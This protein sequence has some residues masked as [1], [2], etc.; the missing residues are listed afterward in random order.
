MNIFPLY[1]FAF[2]YLALFGLATCALSKG[3]LAQDKLDGLVRSD[4]AA[5][6]LLLQKSRANRTALACFG[7]MALLTLPLVALLRLTLG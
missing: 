7:L 4:T 1:L 3:T 2:T 5:R 6:V